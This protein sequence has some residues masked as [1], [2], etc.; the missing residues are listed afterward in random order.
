MSHYPF[1][2]ER[3]PF[4]SMSRKEYEQHIDRSVYGDF[5]LTNAVRPSPFLTPKQGYK[6]SLCRDACQRNIPVLIASITREQIFD[7]F[8]QLLTILPD[9]VDVHLQNGHDDEDPYTLCNEEADLSI[10]QS[11]LWEPEHRELLIDD[12]S[13]GIAVVGPLDEYEIQFDD[14]KLLYAYGKKLGLFR[15]IFRKNDIPHI[16]TLPLIIDAPHIHSTP[17]NHE[18]AFT[19]LAV[20]LHM[21]HSGDDNDDAPEDWEESLF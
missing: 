20:A 14:H 12:G 18:D 17:D 8:Q 19:K 11:T 5:T 15:R 9:T 10:I 16:P 6:E 7:I 3:D 4:E 21:D 1:H 2:R 13:I